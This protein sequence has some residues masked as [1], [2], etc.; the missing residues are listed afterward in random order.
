MA[1]TLAMVCHFYADLMHGTPH[2]FKDMSDSIRTVYLED[3]APVYRGVALTCITDT[4]LK[5]VST[6]SF[7]AQP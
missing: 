4:S 1:V 5:K 7:S 6:A 2:S 3:G